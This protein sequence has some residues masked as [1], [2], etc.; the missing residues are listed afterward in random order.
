MAGYKKNLI[1]PYLY[2]YYSNSNSDLFKLTTTQ[3]FDAQK[4]ASM[5]VATDGEIDAYCLSGIR[6]EDNTGKGAD[7]ND[8]KLIDGF[9]WI[10]V[11][12]DAVIAKPGDPRLFKTPEGINES[13]DNFKAAGFW[14][15]SQ[16]LATGATQP[17]FGQKITMYFEEGS[18]KNSDWAKPRFI[19]PTG[20]PDF[21]DSSFRGLASV[22]GV[23]TAINAFAGG[24]ASLLGFPPTESSNEDINT[25]AARYDKESSGYKS[26]NS[27]FISKMH[28]EF[29]NYIKAFI[30]KCKD[31]KI[32]I[33][34]NSG[35]RSRAEQDRLIA[36]HAAGTRSVKPAVTS[37]HLVG[38]AIDFNPIVNGKWINLSSTKQ[39]WI[40][41]GAVAIGESV[42]LRWGGNF[43]SNYDP[44][45]FDL[46]NKVSVSRMATMVAE[47]K[48]KNVEGIQIP[49]GQKV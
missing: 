25:L 44:V 11:Y 35:Y 24:Y 21:G 17:A 2:K 16:N 32:I 22:L 15:R 20:T 19:A 37:Y 42:G 38:L 5:V 13:I 47:A 12:P 27:R 23:S 41:S 8:A 43:S 33:Y 1:N 45:H 6:T 26:R 46:G 9:L 28:P 36:E 49:T 14:V 39:E 7:I 34:I 31:S 29:Q 18:I 3:L 48:N 40:N 4:D 10:V 30:I